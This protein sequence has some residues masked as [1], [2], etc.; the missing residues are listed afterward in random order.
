M[1]DEQ[2][3]TVQVQQETGFI[4]L[5]RADRANTMNLSMIDEIL[6]ALRETETISVRAWV[7]QHRSPI[8]SAGLDLESTAELNGSEIAV[9]SARFL[10]LIHTIVAA[11]VPVIAAV[12][13]KI[14]GGAAGVVAACDLVLISDKASL[15]LP[16]V[17]SAM[18]PALI[19]PS[20]LNRIPAG[21]CRALGIGSFE[22]AGEELLHC[23]FADRMS[24]NLQALLSDQLKRIVRSQ[25]DAIRTCKELLYKLSDSPSQEKTEMVRNALHQWLS[26]DHQLAIIKSITSGEVPFWNQNLEKHGASSD[27]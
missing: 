8:F 19:L 6:N 24:P 25:P 18:I 17:M 16:E 14:M 10:D 22:I 21:K 3:I 5:N 26:R 12:D 15:S 9:L 2:T 11:P 20:L 13:G 4:T 27:D 7:I 23:G 1:M